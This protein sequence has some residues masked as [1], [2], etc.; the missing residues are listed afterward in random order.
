[1]TSTHIWIADAFLAL[2]V[3]MLSRSREIRVYQATLITLFGFLLAATPLAYPMWAIV[4]AFGML[5]FG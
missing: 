2:Y 5:F 1:M 3:V 4:E